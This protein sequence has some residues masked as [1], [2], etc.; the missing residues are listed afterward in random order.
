MPRWSIRCAWY[1]PADNSDNAL[2]K[3]GNMN[4]LVVDR[5]TSK[6]AQGTCGY[7]ALVEFEKFTGTAPELTAFDPPTGAA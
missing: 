1:D 5:G 2:C 7:T 3:N 6:L 4:V